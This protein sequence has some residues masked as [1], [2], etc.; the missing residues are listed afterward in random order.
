LAPSLAQ[1]VEISEPV[2]DEQSAGGAGLQHVF[3]SSKGLHVEVEHELKSGFSI[4]PFAPSLMQNV[5][6][7]ATEAHVAA[8]AAGL[9]QCAASFTMTHV[10]DKQCSDSGSSIKPLFPFVEQKTLG[11]LI[12]EHSAG[13]AGA[14]HLIASLFVIKHVAVAHCTDAAPFIKPLL[15]YAA[16]KD[17]TSEIESQVAEFDAGAQQVEASAKTLQMAVSQNN[18]VAPYAKPLAPW[19]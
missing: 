12:E 1:K 7:S 18:V 15:P 17:V 5:E 6:G 16:Q 9:Q 2:I 13:G 10:D 4:K 8:S 19:C 14:Q 11:S 3:P